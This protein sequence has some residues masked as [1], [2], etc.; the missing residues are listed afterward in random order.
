MNTEHSTLMNIDTLRQAYLNKTLSPDTLIM[1][2]LE[3]IQRT[4]S[5]NAWI[6]VLSKEQLSPYLESLHTKNIDDHPLW[7]IP[8]AIKDNIDLK[9]VPTTA[10]CPDFAYTPSEHAFVVQQLINAG[11]I[12]MGKTNLDQFATGLVGTRSPYGAVTNAFN[13]EYISGGSSSGSSFA[14]ATGQ[15]SFALGTDTAGS[16]RVPAALNNIIGTKPSIGLLSCRGVVPACK[17]LD[18]VT[19]FTTTQDDA[20][21]LLDVASVYDSEDTYARVA[22]FSKRKITDHFKVGI[23]RNEDL[24]FF[25]HEEYLTLFRQ[26]CSQLEKAGAELVTIDLRIFLKAA[27]LLYNGPWVAERYHAVGSFIEGTTKQCDKTVSTIIKG[28][29]TKTAVDTFDGFYQLA[30][31]KKQCDELLASVDTI[32][33]PTTSNHYKISELEENPIE[34]NSNMGYYTNFINLLDY[35]ALAIPAGFTSTQLP[36][37]I[38]LFA[39]KFEDKQLQQISHKYLAV[40]HWGMG[41]REITTPLSTKSKGYPLSLDGYISVAVCGAHLTGMPLNHQLSERGA[42]LLKASTT[43]QHYQF[44]ALAGG[45]PFR[46][47]LKRV[48]RGESIFIEIWAVP[49]EHFGSFVAGIPAPLGIGKLETIDGDWLSG[50]ICEDYGLEGA[51][52]ITEYKD[53]RLYIKSIS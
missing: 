26:A 25:G 5:S 29:N 21:T 15:V 35:S 13:P 16:G 47:G 7:G 2:C 32:A 4:S 9:G 20:D 44:Y 23:P 27:T 19:F 8:F 36:F 39:N 17:S 12:P 52:N 43:S 28:A 14:V 53:W 42:I 6:S 1:Q 45:P 24:V 50:F 40:K 3:G 22:N 51:N 49:T 30:A 33:M 48:N 10:A 37:G 34:L 46:P 11:A 38:T 41:T 18:C 31:F